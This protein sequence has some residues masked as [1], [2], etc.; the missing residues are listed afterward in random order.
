MGQ[1]ISAGYAHE[2]LD[3]REHAAYISLW[4]WRSIEARER[5]YSQFH[6]IVQHNF[7]RLGHIVDEVRLL[8]TGGIHSE[9][10]DLREM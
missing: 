6:A 8:A 7:E 3:L 10:L 2:R 5:W 9:L 4:S 1:C